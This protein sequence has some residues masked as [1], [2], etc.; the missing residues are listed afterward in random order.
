MW[1]SC[2]RVLPGSAEAQVIWGGTVKRLLSAYFVGNTSA[3]KYQNLLTCVKVIA[4]QRWDVVLRHSVDA[5][6]VDFLPSIN[7][8]LTLLFCMWQ[9]RRCDSVRQ[10]ARATRPPLA[11]ALVA[12]VYNR[13]NEPV[14]AFFGNTLCPWPSYS[15]KKLKLRRVLQ[16]LCGA[17]ERCS[18][19]RL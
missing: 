19:V 4:N 14:V 18:R 8:F 13:Y 5:V 11:F 3:E 16:I 1:F 12:C 10:C 15:A 2:F 7:Q 17:F 6:R 9:L